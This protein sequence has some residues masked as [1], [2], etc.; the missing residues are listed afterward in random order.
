[1]N[2]PLFFTGLG[3]FILELLAFVIYALSQIKISE[4]MIF[5][6]IFG[7]LNIIFVLMMF[8][9]ALKDE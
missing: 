3:F 5:I 9:G 7:G 2:K 6:L 1:M 4:E 8:I